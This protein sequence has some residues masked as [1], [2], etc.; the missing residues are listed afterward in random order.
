MA[1]YGRALLRHIGCILAPLREAEPILRNGI[2]RACRTAEAAVPTWFVV[3]SGEWDAR[4]SMKK[5]T[6]IL[7]CSLIALSPLAR[8]AETQV[9]A[10]SSGLV[11]ITP[12]YHASTLIEAGGKTIYLDPAKPAKFTGLRGIEINRLPSRLDQRAGVI[13]RRDFDQPGGC[14]KDLCFSGTRKR[15][16]GNKRTDKNRCKFL[17]A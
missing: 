13:Q 7:I 1:W 14:S 12:L 17:H 15:R 5:L 10:T 3:T 2:P 6:S 16:Q 8:A 4:S 11:K 9:F